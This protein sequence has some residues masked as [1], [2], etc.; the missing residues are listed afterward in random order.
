MENTKEGEFLQLINNALRNQ[1]NNVRRENESVLIQFMRSNSDEFVELCKNCIENTKLDLEDRV[2]VSTALK[3][4]VEPK[5]GDTSSSIWSNLSDKGIEMIRLLSL[6]NLVDKN[7]AIRNAMAS[8][9]AKG[10]VMSLLVQNPWKNLMQ[11]LSET[12]NN[13]DVMIRRTS[14]TTLGYLCE[15]L[16]QNGVVNLPGN[17]KDMMI[18]AIFDGLDKEDL[19]ETSVLAFLNAAHFFV[20]ELNKE[21]ILE[22]VLNKLI[23]ILLE[24]KKAE[25]N[26]LMISLLHLFSEIYEISFC[27]I[28]RFHPVIVEQVLSNN[29][30]E[31]FTQTNEFFITVSRLDVYW[32]KNA[33]EACWK[34][35][36][37]NVLQ[38]AL[39]IQ[40]DEHE[41][42]GENLYLS[43][44][45]LISSFIEVT[46]DSL[47]DYLTEFFVAYID[48]KSD[49]K[50]VSLTVLEAL[51]EI[52]N[53][54]RIDRF[55]RECF[56]GL[57]ACFVD[58]EF[59]YN[60]LSL[61]IIQVVANNRPYLIF[62]K[63]YLYSILEKMNTFFTSDCFDKQI[64][65]LKM[66]SCKVIQSL[67]RNFN[68]MSDGDRK[69]FHDNTD[70]ILNWL[71]S[72]LNKNEKLPLIDSVILA[73]YELN[74]NA[75]NIGQSNK[76]FMELLN[77]MKFV[78]DTFDHQIK[79]D[80]INLILLCIDNILFFAFNSKQ[81]IVFG[82]INKVVLQNSYLY[83]QDLFARFNEI[84]DGG[85]SYL[86]HLF[87]YKPDYF[88]DAVEKFITDNL[89]KSII[90]PNDEI[91][92]KYTV[93]IIENLML[94]KHKLNEKMIEEF[95]TAN[96]EFILDQLFKEDLGFETRGYLFNY[97]LGIFTFS[98]LVP[99]NHVESFVMKLSELMAQVFVLREL[100]D[101]SKQYSDFL[102]INIIDGFQ[103]IILIGIDLKLMQ[104]KIEILIE[105]IYK[106]SLAELHPP[107]LYLARC[108]T[109]MV[110]L[111]RYKYIDLS[112]QSLINRIYQTIER[113]DVDEAKEAIRY[114]NKYVFM[115]NQA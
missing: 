26:G 98:S 48:N 91:L 64:T 16:K 111:F 25:N 85:L 99:Q 95:A 20:D 61:K 33:V 77:K 94:V 30:E 114:A 109:L 38:L 3:M 7:I 11:N 102:C 78:D 28:E 5:K 32:K 42:E 76:L 113:Q 39:K 4:S 115:Y 55:L 51:S 52:E 43:L 75:L 46:D 62:E 107:V 18:K 17:E 84:L 82:E 100:D 73:I 86:G 9:I 19:V 106:T 40:P 104:F 2:L 93:G 6:T 24:A 97:L 21:E 88:C 1:N 90:N 87:L 60:K 96:F 31:I 45:N 37:D 69:C 57:I 53:N 101:D 54:E 65:S 50:V 110:D 8:L 83:V 12:V 29:N 22:S 89:A 105:F 70:G 44:I 10:Y 68:K 35:V 103:G 36:M 112:H 13:E 80:T 34:D 59:I 41:A 66:I 81:D 47:L 15:D 108:L 92:F 14:I 58:D 56:G 63:Q 79:K 27:I 74:N 49:G 23:T 67:A 72:S 71:I